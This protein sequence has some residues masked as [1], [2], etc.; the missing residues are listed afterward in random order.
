MEDDEGDSD[1]TDLDPRSH[2]EDADDLDD[3]MSED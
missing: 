1:A 2:P 3:Y